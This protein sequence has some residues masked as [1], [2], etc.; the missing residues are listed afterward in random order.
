MTEQ[1]TLLLSF[2]VPGKQG[3]FHFILQKVS[4]CCCLVTKSCQ[5][6][7]DLMDC[8]LPG[9][10]VHGTS[11]GKKNTKVGYHVLFQEIFSNQRLK[12]HLLHWKVDSLPL[13]EPEKPLGIN[14]CTFIFFP[15]GA[16]LQLRSRVSPPIP[17]HVTSSNLSVKPLIR[18]RASKPC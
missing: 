5:T 2:W 11:Q 17:C 6:I 15:L 8:S 4:C 12:L 16:G 13:E 18:R 1:L 10:S 3:L 14:I 9:S 7:C